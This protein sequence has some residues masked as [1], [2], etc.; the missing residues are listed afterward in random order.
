MS[1]EWDRLRRRRPADILKPGRVRLP[2]FLKLQKLGDPLQLR[3]AVP[4][5]DASLGTLE[6]LVGRDGGTP[7]GL[8]ASIP[9]FA[10]PE[11]QDGLLEGPVRRQRVEVKK[12][13]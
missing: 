12:R 9:G 8:K 3:E 7:A 13:V 1:I 11:R 5:G 2:A 6:R 10:F 4:G